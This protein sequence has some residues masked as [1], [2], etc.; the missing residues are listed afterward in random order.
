[1]DPFFDEETVVEEKPEAVSVDLGWESA[2]DD[3]DGPAP[4]SF[5]ANQF[6]VTAITVRGCDSRVDPHSTP[7]G[8][9]WVLGP[10]VV[11]LA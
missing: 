9:R 4:S 11:A 5:S 2:D 10:V 3:D 6:C 8:N 7:S 1:M